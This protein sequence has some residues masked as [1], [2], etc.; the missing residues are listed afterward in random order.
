HTL[1]L[2]SLV[3]DCDNDTLLVRAR[4]AGPTC[5]LGTTSCFGGEDAPGIGWLARRADA[6][7]PAAEP[8]QNA[9]LVVDRAADLLEEL[10]KLLTAARVPLVRVVETLRGRRS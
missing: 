5:H 3:A 6:G 8:A 10:M 4:P 9:Q 2:V 1:D 7:K